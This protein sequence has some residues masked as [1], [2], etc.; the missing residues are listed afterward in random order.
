M[1]SDYPL[2]RRQLIRTH[3]HGEK[4]TVG[5]HQGGDTALEK[6]ILSD[7]VHER[8]ETAFVCTENTTEF[9]KNNI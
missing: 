4:T 9:N 6:N 7:V 5:Q 8:S 1:F 3:R 2:T